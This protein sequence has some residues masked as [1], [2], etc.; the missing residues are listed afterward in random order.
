M[1]Q[2]HM[3]NLSKKVQGSYSVSGLT[4]V[5]QISPMYK[6]G[7]CVGGT[8]TETQIAEV[9]LQHP[10]P[11]VKTNNHKHQHTH[12]HTHPTEYAKEP[13]LNQE[14]SFDFCYNAKNIDFFFFP[15]MA[16]VPREQTHSWRWQLHR[17]QS[18]RDSQNWYH[19]PNSDLLPCLQPAF[20]WCNFVYCKQ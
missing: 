14:Q 9:S 16:Y 1:C 8:S 19:T 3:S 12:T 11:N 17:N 2:K 20:K 6:P 7:T 13:I 15:W 10:N 18:V 4:A 5:M